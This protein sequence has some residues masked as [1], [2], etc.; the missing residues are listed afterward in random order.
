MFQPSRPSSSRP[1]S[2]VS[3]GSVGPSEQLLDI[4]ERLG[5]LD[6]DHNTLKG[7]VDVIEVSTLT[8]LSLASIKGTLV[9]SVDP[10]QMQQNM[11]SD[12]VYA[13]CI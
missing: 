10:D 6:D 2:R 9:N 1:M 11:A 3:S 12:Q 8:H 4:L 13:V 7:R 5:R